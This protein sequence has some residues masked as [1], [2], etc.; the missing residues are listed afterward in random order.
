MNTNTGF[1]DTVN[2]FVPH[3]TT[4][5]F[6][7]DILT[8][9]NKKIDEISKIVNVYYFNIDSILID[10]SDYN[11]LNELGYI[12]D[13][14]GGFKIEHVFTEIAIKSSKIFVGTLIDGCKFY[15]CANKN[16]DYNSF[17]REVR[18]DEKM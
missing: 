10:E 11:K 7:L 15:H 3:F 16:V 4:P 9:F 8:N 5:Q 2:S 1:V 13:N 18:G 17:I 12:N 14:L 6:A